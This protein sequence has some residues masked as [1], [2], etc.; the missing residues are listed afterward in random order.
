MWH[1]SPNIVTLK[2]FILQNKIK[3]IYHTLFFV[4][5]HF[6]IS[7]FQYFLNL[8]YYNETRNLNL[9]YDK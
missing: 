3:K 5:V 8:S 7:L 4:T 1:T 9:N 2:S 6:N